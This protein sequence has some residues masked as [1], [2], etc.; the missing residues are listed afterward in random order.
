MT[1]SASRSTVTSDPALAEL[2]EAYESGK[3]V[4]FAGAGVSAAAGLPGWKRLVELLSERARAR[5]VAD[6]VLQEIAELTAARQF[7][8]ALSALKDCLGAPDFCTVIERHLDDRLFKEP[9]VVR[10]IAALAPRLRA[11]LTTN[12]DH[13]F[14]RA[15]GGRWPM[16]PRATG[17]IVQRDHFIL[18]LH[19]TLIDRSSWVFT[20]EEYDRASFADPALRDAFTA[21]FH[22]HHLLFVGYGLADDDFDLHLARVRAFAGAQPPRHFALVSA[23]TV[24]PHRRKKMEAAGIRLIAYENPDGKHTAVVEFLR[25]LERPAAA[26]A[27][28]TSTASAA[29]EFDEV[30]RLIREEGYEVSTSPFG[31]SRRDRK[32]SGHPRDTPDAAGDG[33][34]AHELEDSRELNFLLRVLRSLDV[35]T[36]WRLWLRPLA[37][38]NKPEDSGVAAALALPEQGGFGL[39]LPARGLGSSAGWLSGLATK[40]RAHG[41]AVYLA[42]RRTPETSHAPGLEPLGLREVLAK[43]LDALL[44]SHAQRCFANWSAEAER[45]FVAARARVHPTGQVLPVSEALD[46]ALASPGKVLVLGDFGTGKS[47][48]LRRLAAFMARAFLEGTAGAPAPVHLP[49]GGSGAELHELVSRHLPE[50]DTD[51]LRLAVELGLVVPLFDGLDEARLEPDEVEGSVDMLLANFPGPEARAVLTSRKTLFPDLARFIG[52]RREGAGLAI[53]ELEELNSSEVAD[54]VRRRTASAEEKALVLE[55]I[56]RTHDL[57]SLS[58][59]PFLLE[60]ILKSQER[61]TSGEMTPARLYALAVEDWLDSRKA[62]ERRVLREQ[63]LAFA[64]GLAR[65]LFSRGEDTAAHRTVTA[66]VLEVLGDGYTGLNADEAA[67][68]VRTAVFL[69]HDEERGGFLFAHKSFLEY[70]LAV[71][72][73]MR[74]RDAREDALELPRLT[75]EVVSFLAGLPDWEERREQLRWL[76]LRQPLGGKHREGVRENALLALY[77]AARERVGG[78]EALGL[79]LEAELPEKADLAGAKL[80]GLELPWVALPG[81]DLTGADLSEARLLM[82]DLRGARLD[83]ANLAHA[84]LDGAL[85]G[86]ARL[87]E[88]DLFGAS[89]VDAAV[90]GVHWEAAKR[91]A[92]I[93]LFTEPTQRG[94]WEPSAPVPKAVLHTR[95]GPVNTMAWSPDRRRLVSG[96]ADGTVRVWDAS[97]G[98]ALHVLEG[99][100]RGVSTVAYSPD[101]ARV[102]SG[103]DDGTVRVWDASSGKALHVLE[104]HQ[105]WVRTVAYSP[106]G[107]RVASGGDDGTVRVWDASSGKALHVLEGHQGW[108]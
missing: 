32:Q 52:Q 88:A 10:A 94:A 48:H 33:S 82:A 19:G 54:F 65:A 81:A 57:T 76:L 40:L 64:R 56:R 103:G 58:K 25:E 23:D 20:R 61:L 26:A 97:S 36:F 95:S 29:L 96:G 99:H 4:I 92:L 70:F 28:S 80:S 100:K 93:D 3:L 11:V 60:L 41:G 8:D 45:G 75:P 27:P 39:Y 9:E 69:A 78:G 89:L 14:E 7:I 84:T 87:V 12:I 106:D 104:G 35:P 83:R 22:A 59:R 105:G 86:G 50:L 79:A 107:A 63:R 37:Q 72:I 38:G 5:G 13:L 17:D 53:L 44:R 16:L 49:L 2:R 42:D 77:L 73:A 43:R 90:A 47:T 21:F 71:D 98:K 51:A 24:K 62:G 102:A 46:Q 55:K 31:D 18:K 108:V 68:E 74:L 1:D 15:F 34:R 101:G 66:F 91:E 67:Q 85:L 6:A 30:M